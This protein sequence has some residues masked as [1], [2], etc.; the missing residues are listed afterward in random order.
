MSNRKF[1]L[2]Y[3]AICFQGDY[4]KGWAGG[5]DSSSWV[6]SLAQAS[7]VRVVVSSKR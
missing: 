5:Q 7:M 4:G 1:D 6:R 2:L 3:F